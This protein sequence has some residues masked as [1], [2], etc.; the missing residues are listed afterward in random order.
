LT[1]VRRICHWC[2][3]DAYYENDEK[4]LYWCFRCGVGGT[5]DNWQWMEKNPGGIPG[6]DKPEEKRE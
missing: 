3:S 6:R 4:R 5:Y 2:G 1:A